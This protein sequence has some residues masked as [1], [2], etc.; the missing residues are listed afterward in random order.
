MSLGPALPLFLL[1]LAA[2]GLDVTR[3]GAAGWAAAADDLRL[4]KDAGGADAGAL[5]PARLRSSGAQ[6]V[7]DSGASEVGSGGGV[8]D[9]RGGVGEGA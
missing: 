2:Y 5:A 4:G 6:R 1:A 7:S 3:A 9:G 8:K